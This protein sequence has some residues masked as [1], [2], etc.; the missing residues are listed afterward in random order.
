LIFF[1]DRLHRKIILE[2]AYWFPRSAYSPSVESRIGPKRGFGLT[3]GELLTKS[4]TN[5]YPKSEKPPWGFSPEK[6]RTQI[7]EIPWVD[8]TVGLRAHPRRRRRRRWRPRVVRFVEFVKWREVLVEVE[9]DAF[10]VLALAAA[11]HG[12]AALIGL[13]VRVRANPRWMWSEMRSAYSPSWLPPTAALPNWVK[14]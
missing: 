14:G 10:R 6:F 7:S 13:R 4:K 5:P 3:P 11:A 1:Q 9:R 12:S 8:S 2:Y